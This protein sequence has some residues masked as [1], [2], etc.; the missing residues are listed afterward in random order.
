MLYCSLCGERLDLA[1]VR[2]CR[3]CGTI[4]C[5]HCIRQQ[6]NDSADLSNP[7][8]LDEPFACR[9]CTSEDILPLEDLRGHLVRDFLSV[10]QQ[11]HTNATAPVRFLQELLDFRDEVVRVGERF[12]LFPSDFTFTGDLSSTFA[13]AEH[14]A[15]E[16]LNDFGQNIRSLYDHLIIGQD[17]GIDPEEL[18]T[19]QLRLRMLTDK[20]RSFEQGLESYFKPF[21]EEFLKQK[22]LYKSFL[23]WE[24]ELRELTTIRDQLDREDRVLHITDPLS[25]NFAGP[26]SRSVRLLLSTQR[27]VVFQHPKFRLRSKVKLLKVLDPANIHQV[28]YQRRKL[29]S[30]LL[31]LEGLDM[32]GQHYCVEFGAEEE[33][34]EPLTSLLERLKQQEFPPRPRA[35]KNWKVHWSAES[36]YGNIDRILQF[37][38]RTKVEDQRHECQDGLSGTSPPVVD[39][40]TQ[41]TEL[42]EYFERQLEQLSQKIRLVEYI[43][44]DLKKRKNSMSVH[45][46]YSLYENFSLKLRSLESDRNALLTQYSRGL[47]AQ[48]RGRGVGN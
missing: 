34:L 15:L 27:L 5:P 21:Q 42:L 39:G 25:S 32:D 37:E 17:N 23:V 13:T 28:I 8:N 19:T 26:V 22:E 14:F 47:S 6:S 41:Q 43:I 18:Q 16:Y 1:E 36:Y 44:S 11:L 31:R 38:W 45:E 20:L 2:I 29:R 10:K 12:V 30:P 24:E 40:L 4:L 35:W 46:F 33:C 9:N 48:Q 3:G 7:T